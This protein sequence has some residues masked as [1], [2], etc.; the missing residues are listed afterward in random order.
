MKTLRTLALG[1]LVAGVLFLGY[2]TYQGIQERAILQYKVQTLDS[3]IVSLQARKAQ[4]DTIYV[5][6]KATVVRQKARR[7]TIDSSVRGKVPQMLDSVAA[8]LLAPDTASKRI[9]TAFV[10]ADSV[11]A[12]L[13]SVVAIADTKD[14]VQDSIITTQAQEVTILKGKRSFWGKVGHGLKV[15]AKYTGVF[16]VGVVG[17]ILLT[18]TIGGS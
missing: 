17:G 15:G 8:G 3:T 1:A 5:A 13:D 12:A 4:I 10:A 9:E 16:A 14:V 18:K 11:I 6:Q 2:T 7:A